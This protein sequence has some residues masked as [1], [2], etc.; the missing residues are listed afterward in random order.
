MNTYNSAE[1]PDQNLSSNL[2]ALAL[3]QPLLQSYPFIPLTTSSIKPNNLAFL[4]NDVTLNQRKSILEFGS[5][6]STILMGRL[7]R[8]N[9]LDCKIISVEHDKDWIEFVQGYIDKDGTHEAVQMIYAPLTRSENALDENAWYDT[10]VLEK[11]VQGIK[12]DMVVID[13]PPAWEPNKDRARYPA[14]SFIWNRLCSKAIVCLDDANRD[15]EKDIL[16]KWEGDYRIKFNYTGTL[17]YHVR[18]NAFN[19]LIK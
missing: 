12:F 7:I 17:A 5:G 16:A 4:L 11:S 18:G 1:Q 13:G 3:I 2:Y 10:R 15:G 14:F 9:G 19:S 6:I 8:K